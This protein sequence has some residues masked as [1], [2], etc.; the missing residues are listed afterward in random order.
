ME[1]WYWYA[2]VE[3]ISKKVSSITEKMNTT[4]IIQ[5]ITEKI[6]ICREN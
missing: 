6:A 2:A 5:V 1:V 3:R 4:V